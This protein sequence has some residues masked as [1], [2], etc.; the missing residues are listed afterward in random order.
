MNGQEPVPMLSGE[1]ELWIQ[2][3]FHAPLIVGSNPTSAGYTR[4][5]SPSSPNSSATPVHR[6]II[7]G[8]R[9]KV[10]LPLLSSADDTPVQSTSY[11]ATPSRGCSPH[12]LLLS[13]FPLTSLPVTSN[14]PIG[15]SPTTE[16][17]TPEKYSLGDTTPPRGHHVSHTPF[18]SSA[19][20]GW[21]EPWRT[22]DPT[23]PL[24]GYS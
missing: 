22:I 21:H 8:G 2:D 12:H 4:P 1:V 16:A 24:M 15:S 11:V 23:R 5:P 7:S 18:T 13:L 19:P 3:D 14:L 9:Y 10:P 20:G 6:R 17:A